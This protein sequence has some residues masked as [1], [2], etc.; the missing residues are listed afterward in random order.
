MYMVL[1]LVFTVLVRICVIDNDI[2]KFLS[3]FIER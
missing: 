3:V 2:K 1:S